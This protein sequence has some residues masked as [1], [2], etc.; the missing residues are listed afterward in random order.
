M[1]TRTESN[2]TQ[3]SSWRLEAPAHARCTNRSSQ[4]PDVP[5]MSRLL[6]SRIVAELPAL[7][8]QCARRQAVLVQPEYGSSLLGIGCEWASALTP[9][10]W[11]RSAR[12][13][14][15]PSL[16]GVLPPIRALAPF[17]VQL[18]LLV[19]FLRQLHDARIALLQL[20]LKLAYTVVLSFGHVVVLHALMV[21][22]LGTAR[23]AR[24]KGIS[25]R[26]GTAR[27]LQRGQAFSGSCSVKGFR[28]L[29]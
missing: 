16:D 25:V 20:G 9:P 1:D 6:E 10:A 29:S 22:R 12:R 27:G 2:R 18:P 5:S 4:C 14:L 11:R 15:L 17:V 7:F 21:G 13:A 28:E 3:A 26:E 19:A 24:F 8:G 23:K